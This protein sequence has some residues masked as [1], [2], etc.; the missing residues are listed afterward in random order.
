M[1][2]SGIWDG[3]E[4]SMYGGEQKCMKAIGCKPWRKETT[5]KPEQQMIA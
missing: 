1:I 5:W 3:W 4:C 2:K